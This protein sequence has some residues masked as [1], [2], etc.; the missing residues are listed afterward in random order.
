MC[1]RDTKWAQIS[2]NE[3]K[4]KK[5]TNDAYQLRRDICSD[6]WSNVKNIENKDKKVVVVYYLYNFQATSS[7][8]PQLTTQSFKPNKKPHKFTKP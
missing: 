7:D 1:Q 5:K 8:A 4:L 2:L 6:F 3:L